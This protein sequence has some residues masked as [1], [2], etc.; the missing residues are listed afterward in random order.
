[1]PTNTASSFSASF[2]VNELGEDSVQNI[3]QMR[4]VP[5]LNTFRVDVING[6]APNLKQGSLGL[7]QVMKRNA[8]RSITSKGNRHKL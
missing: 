7:I 3:V 6:M 4:R 1:M 5:D 8:S 2:Q